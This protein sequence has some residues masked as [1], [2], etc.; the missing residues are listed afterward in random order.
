MTVDS[1]GRGMPQVTTTGGVG[2]TTGVA[3]TPEELKAQIIGQIIA[4]MK[5]VGVSKNEDGKAPPGA[6]VLEPP[7]VSFS[8]E[9]AALILGALQ[10]KLTES[11][12]K[13]AKEG[14]QMDAQKKQELHQ[15][16]MKKLEE[17]AKKLAE[18][19]ALKK[20]NFILNIVAKIAAVV[21]SAIALVA[22]AALTVATAGAAAPLLA[23]A[24]IG[25]A[26]AVIDAGFTAAD[27]ISRSLGGPE[28]TIN[29]LLTKA[30]AEILK[31][32]GVDEKKAQEIGGWVAMGIQLAVAVTMVVISI[33]ATI[34]TGGIGAPM[35]LGS[36]S[37]ITNIVSGIVQ[38]GLAVAQGGLTIATA[39]AEKDAAH[40]QADKLDIEKLMQKLQQ[41]MEQE[42]E[43]IQELIE[44]LEEGM[45][46]VMSIIAAGGETR[47][48]IARNMV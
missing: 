40:A 24:A 5:N 20:A 18:A 34:A 37:A 19:S 14:V 48:Q 4:D 16:A 47:M 23:V 41:M 10:S 2:Q 32:F 42:G 6:P 3:P 29:A 7:T 9:D 31:A 38:G 44:K 25:F 17:A 21:V 15:E 8:A 39:V 26:M 28:L 35:L 36:L 12:L 1:V 11:Q 22:A 30:T 27:A 13:T 45:Q 43:R 33:A 46:R